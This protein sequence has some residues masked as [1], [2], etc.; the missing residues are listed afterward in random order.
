MTLNEI[1][2]NPKVDARELK[3]ALVV[4]MDKEG[5]PRKQIKKIFNVIDSYI[6]R[7]CSLYKDNGEDASILLLNYKGSRPYLNK[8]QK[9]EIME[10]LN[11]KDSITLSTFKSYVSSKYNVVFKSDQSYYDLLKLGNMSWKKTQKKIL[12]RT[13]GK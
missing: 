13:R 1:V 12:N 6:S 4:K 5:T 3:R 8:E 2:S 9:L 7:W 10:Y 11:D